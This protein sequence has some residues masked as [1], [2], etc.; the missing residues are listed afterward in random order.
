MT[1]KIMVLIVVVILVVVF[2]GFF[3]FFNNDTG[4]GENGLREGN[5]FGKIVSTITGGE[6]RPQTQDTQSGVIEGSIQD[7]P[8]GEGGRL[9][10]LTSL[11]ISG[12]VATSTTLP[13]TT[14]TNTVVRYV[15]RSSGNVFEVDPTSLTQKRISNT[16]VPGIHEVFW[17]KDAEKLLVRYL[18][19]SDVIK[20]FSAQLKEGEDN[21]F[22]LVGD[23]LKNNI[24]SITTSPGEDRLLYVTPINNVTVGIV[25]DFDG[26][27]ADVLFS[28]P[29]SEW[30]VEWVNEDIVALT[31]KAAAGIPGYLYFVDISSGAFEK[32]LGGAQ[33]LTT[34]V[35]SA[36]QSVLFAEGSNSTIRLQVL[37]T[38]SREVR[39]LPFSTLPEKCVWSNKNLDTL[40]CGVPSVVRS[41]LYP[42]MWYKGILSFTDD[43]LEVNTKTG[44]ASV[45]I[46]PSVATE[47]TIDLMNPF[48]SPG[49]DFL[50]FTNKKDST[51]WGLRLDN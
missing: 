36:A 19:D 31:T 2:L 25:S 47:E 13:N 44:A 22:E 41:G 51:L 48:L 32:I 24:A 29:F 9:R 30:S 17:H 4:G 5:F 37:D 8:Q 11:P 43:V 6:R 49:E 35:N 42:D 45:L 1:K 39:G 18:T 50:F 10:Q 23:F 3:F 26:G 46:K 16:T 20:S 38:I 21:I 34:A 27:N 7:L 40:Y 12:A 28:T 33:G 15:D 14:L